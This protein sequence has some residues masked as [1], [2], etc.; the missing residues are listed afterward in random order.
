[1]KADPSPFIETLHE[2]LVTVRQSAEAEMDKLD[3]QGL[4]W[5]EDHITQTCWSAG[6]PV[7]KVV[8]FTQPQEGVVGADWLWWWVDDSSGECFGM[9]IQA[10]RLKHEGSRWTVDVRY[11]NGEQY[12]ALLAA[13]GYFKVPAIYTVYLGGKIL[14]AERD[15]SHSPESPPECVSCDRSAISVISAYELSAT[16]SPAD[17]AAQILGDGV[18]LEDLADP[19]RPAGDV[20]DLNRSDLSF[21]LR[22]FLS[23]PQEGPKEVA[24][25]IFGAVSRM[26]ALQY[27]VDVEVLDSTDFGQ[28]FHDLPD[29]QGHFPG[30]YYPHILDGLRKSLPAGFQALR[31]GGEPPAELLERLAGVVFITMGSPTS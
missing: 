29:D 14:R 10:K 15:C 25:R 11:R 22:E 30:A 26:R 5:H 13:A 7:L 2:A 23:R 24:K 4:T 12:R 28:M 8:P 27:S 19:D 18:P 17:S 16:S 3:I 20:W 9:L 21:E 31:D 6:W 1:M